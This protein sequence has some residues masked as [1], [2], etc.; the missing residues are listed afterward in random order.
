MHDYMICIDETGSP[1]LAHALFGNKKG[2]Q[3][4]DH[5]WYARENVK[6]SW[7]YWYDPES[8]RS[9]K[10][11]VKKKVNNV[12]EDIRKTAD[13]YKNYKT[14]S[15][16]QN[17]AYK[18][19]KQK[20]PGESG[21]SYLYGIDKYGRAKKKTDDARKGLRK[22]SDIGRVIVDTSDKVNDAIT[23]AL[24]N[25]SDPRGT[26]SKTISDIQKELLYQGV[27]IERKID[28]GPFSEVASIP[29]FKKARKKTDQFLK[30]TFGKSYTK[31]KKNLK[32]TI[33]DIDKELTWLI[34]M[35]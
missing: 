19:Y 15:K 32:K 6:G 35:S 3:K 27:K 34:E 10:S 7:R 23:N 21:V 24:S 28:P 30:K 8:Y 1:Y 5:K 12:K 25:L 16:K 26:L 2:S 9:W 22:S 20:H 14:A 31:I 17:D 33:R 11:G 13:A 18:E 4:K 29:E